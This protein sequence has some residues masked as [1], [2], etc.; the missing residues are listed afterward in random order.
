MTA[1]W[2]PLDEALRAYRAGETWAT[3]SV[4]TDVGGVEEMPVAHFFR[5]PGDMG[6]VESAALR[7]ASGRTLDV[8]A[9][10]GA[11]AV[12]LIRRGLA[13]TAVAILWLAASRRAGAAASQPAK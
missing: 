7:L 10:P 6:P 11:H 9:G 13:V 3:V 12:P 4:R 5:A 8:G 1:S 2:N